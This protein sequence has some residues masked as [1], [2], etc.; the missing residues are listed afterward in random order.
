MLKGRFFMNGLT[1]G[2][3]RCVSNIFLPTGEQTPFQIFELVMITY[4][5]DCGYELTGSN[6]VAWFNVREFLQVK[7]LR[8]NFR[9]YLE[10]ESSAHGLFLRWELRCTYLE[11]L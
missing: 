4:V 2:I 6:V 5:P 9:G 7:C 10:G 8:K 1:T 3:D 11:R